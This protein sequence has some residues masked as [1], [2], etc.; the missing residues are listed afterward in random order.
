MPGQGLPPLSLST[1]PAVSD[2]RSGL[3]DAFSGAFYFKPQQSVGLVE[4]LAPLALVA[5][6]AWL[7]TRR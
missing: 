7:L 2:A 6:V 3:G 1:G 4:R 5:G